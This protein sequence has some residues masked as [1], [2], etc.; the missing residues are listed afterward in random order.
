MCVFVCASIVCVSRAERLRCRCADYRRDQSSVCL[1]F[2]LPWSGG[3]GRHAARSTSP[4]CVTRT[5]ATTPARPT[6]PGRPLCASTSQ[7]VGHRD[8]S[9]SGQR[10]Q[11]RV[12]SHRDGSEV[13]ETGQK[14]QRRVR[15]HRDGSETGQRSQKRVKDGSEVTETGQRSDRDRAEVRQRSDGSVVSGQYLCVTSVVRAVGA[16][17]VRGERTGSR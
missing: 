9:E 12:R 14:S 8:G 13:T 5:A 4:T 1:V 10:S 11:R 6:T 7:K 15:G 2:R 16:L 3:R 17:P